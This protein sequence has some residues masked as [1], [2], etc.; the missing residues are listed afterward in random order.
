MQA[1]NKRWQW[2]KEKTQLIS[3]ECPSQNWVKPMTKDKMMI[4][5]ISSDL[6]SVPRGRGLCKYSTP[7]KKSTRN[8]MAM[9]SM[10]SHLG[11]DTFRPN[12]QI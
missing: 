11:D 6:V 3:A 1:K 12:D 9:T 5:N 10:L 8:T 7:R 4:S 2:E